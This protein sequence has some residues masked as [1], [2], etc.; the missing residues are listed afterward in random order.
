MALMV[1][2]TRMTR[3]DDDDHDDDNDDERFQTSVVRRCAQ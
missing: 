2:V 1:M 3:Y